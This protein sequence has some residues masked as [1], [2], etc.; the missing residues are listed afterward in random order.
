VLVK[1]DLKNMLAPTYQ[2]DKYKYK[3]L[4]MMQEKK[5]GY[6]RIHVHYRKLNKVTAIHPLPTAITIDVLVQ[7]EGRK[8]YPYMDGFL[9][10]N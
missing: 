8:I 2:V 9:R 10:Y 4:H 1:M 5:S 7:V 6:M 3:G